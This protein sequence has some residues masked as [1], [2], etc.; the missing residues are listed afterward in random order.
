[1]IFLFYF[2][3]IALLLLCGS[4]RFRICLGVRSAATSCA[5]LEILLTAINGGTA[6]STL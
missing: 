5:R 2:M 3:G 4:D 1:M 6:T